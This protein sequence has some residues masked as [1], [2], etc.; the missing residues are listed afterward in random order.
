MIIVEFFFIHLE[1]ISIFVIFFQFFLHVSCFFFKA[2]SKQIFPT[3][4]FMALDIIYKSI[5]VCIITPFIPISSL[6]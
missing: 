3:K 2:I 6:N 5:W 4:I 1:S